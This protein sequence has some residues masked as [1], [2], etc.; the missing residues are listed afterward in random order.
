MVKEKNTVSGPHMPTV[1]STG[2]HGAGL[3][4]EPRIITW[5]LDSS[6]DNTVES[7]LKTEKE[8]KNPTLQE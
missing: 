7:S 8:K 1:P 6:M 2:L 4:S 3:S 5:Q